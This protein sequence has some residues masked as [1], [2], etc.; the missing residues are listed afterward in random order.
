VGR[1]LQTNQRILS[2]ILASRPG[3]RG[4]AFDGRYVQ[5][6]D[7]VAPRRLLLFGFLRKD[8]AVMDPG[9]LRLADERK[10]YR[11]VV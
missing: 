7:P 8:S 1:W 2:L 10:V 9:A 5:P 3:N 4:Q 6:L 11:S